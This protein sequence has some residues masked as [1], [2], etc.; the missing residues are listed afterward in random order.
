MLHTLLDM[1]FVWPVFHPAGF[2]Q[3]WN[4]W[5]DGAPDSRCAR[6]SMPL[7]ELLST[8]A[9]DHHSS[10][11]GMGSWH[12]RVLPMRL[13]AEAEESALAAHDLDSKGGSASDGPTLRLDFR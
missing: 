12:K 8:V 1:H 9:P 2:A 3:V 13:D 11:D 10:H 6:G 4:T 7:S 5:A